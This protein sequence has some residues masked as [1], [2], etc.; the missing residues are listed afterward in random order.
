MPCDPSQEDPPL[1]RSHLSSNEH[2]QQI[3]RRI[4]S[5]PVAAQHEDGSLIRCEVHED[6]ILTA[7]SVADMP[8]FMQ[9]VA[10]RILTKGGKARVFKYEGEQ[11]Q[12]NQPVQ[13]YFI[14][15]KLDEE[16]VTWE[17]NIR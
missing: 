2:A 8:S 11:P 5:F 3:Y 10:K 1:Q 15:E 9:E 16:R 17:S 14:G 13:L 7:G 6:E 12:V 4:P